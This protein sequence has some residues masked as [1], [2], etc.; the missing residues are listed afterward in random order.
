MDKFTIKETIESIDDTSSIY[1]LEILSSSSGFFCNDGKLLFIAK[2]IYQYPSEGIETDYLKLRT[3]LRISAVKNNQSFKDDHYNIIIYKGDL[4]GT[5]FDSF[6]NLCMIYA[7]NENDL[8]FKEFFYSLINLFQL[9]SEQSFK[10][11]IGLYGELKLMQYAIEKIGTDISNSWHRNGS[12]SKYDF[13]NGKHSLEVKT[14]LSEESEI[15]IKHQQIFGSHPCTLV[16]INC[17][18][19]ENGETIEELLQKM[20]ALPNA[21]NGINFSLNLSKELKRV[22]EKDVKTL[23]FDICQIQFFDAS[24][25][26]PFPSIPDEVSKLSYKLDTSSFDCLSNDAVFSCISTF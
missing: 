14:T 12:Y 10:N 15:S 23:R 4:E 26:N 20:F 16:V 7:N 13:S 5:N 21:F 2:D 18:Q 8:N 11:V 3:H 24:I 6:I 9:P 1:L 25:I 19:Y 17:E 22:S